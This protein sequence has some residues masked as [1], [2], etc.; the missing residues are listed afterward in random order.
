MSGEKSLDDLRED[1]L[2]PAGLT[3]PQ[4]TK[5]GDPI[6]AADPSVG[7]SSDVDFTDPVYDISRKAR[8]TLGSYL[9]KKTSINKY[10][11]SGPI[12]GADPVSANAR[13][14]SL[15]PVS[16]EQPS[17]VITNSDEATVLKSSGLGIPKVNGQKLGTFF[18]SDQ[19]DQIL[20]KTSQTPS[21]SG[22]D[23]LKKIPID[24]IPQIS[25][26]KPPQLPAGID[27]NDLSQTKGALMLSSIHQQLLEGNAYS[28]DET[29]KFILDANAKNEEEALRRIFTIQRDLGFF[30]KNGQEV[31]VSDM[32]A[33]AMALIVRSA[34]NNV[35]S[36]YII[37]DKNLQ[38]AGL[39]GLNPFVNVGVVGVGAAD[40]RIG[41]VGEATGKIADLAAAATGQ[42][43]FIQIE[44][45][46][47]FLTKRL[48]PNNSGLPDL[49]SSSGNKTSYGQLTT[50]LNPFGSKFSSVGM[51][52]VAVGSILVILGVSFLVSIGLVSSNPTDE[53]KFKV[54]LPQDYKFGANKE[55]QNFLQKI[56]EITNT[57]YPFSQCVSLGLPLL[58]GFSGTESSFKQ[59]LTT[60]NIQS[61]LSN[62]LLSSGYY[63]NF[64]RSIVVEGT[65]IVGNFG[66]SLGAI[67]TN[68]VG[69][70]DEFLKG[71]EKLTN[72]SIYK[73]IQIAA[74]LGD[75]QLKS[76]LG[77]T[78]VS[79]FDVMIK[80]EVQQTI[81]YNKQKK[82]Q[83]GLVR[84]QISR[85]SDGSLAQSLKTYPAARRDL[86]DLGISQVFD[87]IE[88]LTPSR[89]NVK[90][91]EDRL[92]AEYMPF[93]IHDLRTH[94]VFSM[95]AFITEFSENF[96]ANYGAIKG[97]GRQDPVRLYQDT[98]RSV[99]LSFMLVAMSSKDFDYM[100]Y[101]INR[102]VAMCYPQYSK[103][104]LRKTPSPA[105]PSKIT[106]FIQP[107]SQ[108]QAASPL[109]RLRVGD[110]FKS[111]YSKFG[112]SRLF[113]VAANNIEKEIDKNRVEYQKKKNNAL[114]KIHK[115]FK[116]ALSNPRDLDKINSYG[117]SNIGSASALIMLKENA[118]VYESDLNLK[119][120][121]ELTNNFADLEQSEIF[122]IGKRFNK[123]DPIVFSTDLGGLKFI[124]AY[125]PVKQTSV[126]L[127]TQKLLDSFNAEEGTV[128]CYFQA[129]ENV[130][131]TLLSSI[132]GLNPD[133]ANSQSEKDP[134]VQ[135]ARK[136]IEENSVSFPDSSFFSREKNSVVRSF[137]TTRGRGLAGFITSLGLSY[138]SMTW[139]T[140]LGKRAP[141]GVKI[142]MGF[143]PIHDLP[144]GL[145]YDG[146]IR[147]PSHPVGNYA[148]SFGDPY[149]D[150]QVK[151]EGNTA[152]SQIMSKTVSKIS[153]TDYNDA[154]SNISNLAGRSTIKNK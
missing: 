3:N 34:G 128:F 78:S 5:L 74:A 147:N 106:E 10:Q 51:F 117:R 100:W 118:I 67:G 96:A 38:L 87:T 9:S 146:N 55:N 103:G 148:G 61:G 65:E 56:L 15:S 99:T 82:A 112:L 47:N 125:R 141:K 132:D 136:K 7:I 104:R 46:S 95:P 42:K 119:E 105:D 30:N 120:F 20:D 60:E 115:D 75:I 154:L 85:W 76:I 123:I 80:K 41:S 142:T 138:E 13:G 129:N 83:L 54:K 16:S 4:F 64:M 133:Y 26:G 45:D 77:Q 14:A 110:V 44:S 93:Y 6:S 130:Y 111:N 31:K 71:I 49:Q 102:F 18:T 151:I 68:V 43:D 114:T 8:Q 27:P 127:E 107:F 21:K 122:V 57:D 79:A 73:L 40:L 58:F 143:T 86:T 124:K 52:T 23:L 101:L 144:L 29:S 89:E 153:T 121:S 150:D 35:G 24:G 53:A 149:D 88:S 97:V 90:E 135:E 91:I 36:K 134:E 33:M 37:N 1:A 25:S 145:D 108:V 50:F 92:E 12:P 11:V 152:S 17:F 59:A 22:D 32:S 109:V 70:R 81:D 28:P 116:I 66:S 84:K 19:L 94:E 39:T 72:S 140:E 62:L 137:E 98:E 63:A 113:G 69:G 2:G 126:L 139:E 48:L 131:V